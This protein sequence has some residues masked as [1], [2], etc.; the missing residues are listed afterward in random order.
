MFLSVLTDVVS[1]S[2]VSGYVHPPAPELRALVVNLV[3]KSVFELASLL[4]LFDIFMEE[5]LVEFLVVIWW[6][7]YRFYFVV[8]RF[9]MQVPM[10]IFSYVFVTVVYLFGVLWEA[11]A[12]LARLTWNWKNILRI[13]LYDKKTY[14]LDGPP[15]IIFLLAISG[16]QMYTQTH[17][18]KHCLFAF[19]SPV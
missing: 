5:V 1:C 7:K 15:L 18:C 14:D 19:Q 8:L 13:T 17:V 9:S 2:S 4:E 16:W 6:H 3:D 12:E 10:A 11:S